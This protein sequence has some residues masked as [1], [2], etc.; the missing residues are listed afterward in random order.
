MCI[1]G[2]LSKERCRRRWGWTRCQ[3]S[4]SEPGWGL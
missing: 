1:S 4:T 3:D 2:S